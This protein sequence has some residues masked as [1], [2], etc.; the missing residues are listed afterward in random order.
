[1]NSANHACR[2]IRGILIFLCVLLSSQAVCGSLYAAEGKAALMRSARRWE[3]RSKLRT[4]PL[5]A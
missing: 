2:I 4:L 3:C 5:T 1:M